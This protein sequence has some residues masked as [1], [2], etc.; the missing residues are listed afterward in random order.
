MNRR[1]QEIRLKNGIKQSE[2]AQKLDITVASYSRKEN[3]KLR[4]SLS[5]AIKIASIFEMTVEEIFD[6]R[7][8]HVL[9]KQEL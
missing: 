7:H 4:F 8:F 1:L 9:E 3:G 5:E 6:T 2:M